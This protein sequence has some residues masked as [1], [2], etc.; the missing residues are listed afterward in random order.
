MEILTEPST[1]KIGEILDYKKIDS[2]MV[3]WD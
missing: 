2:K 1:G 3:D